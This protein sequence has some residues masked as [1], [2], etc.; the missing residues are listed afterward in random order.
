MKG[1]VVVDLS[2]MEEIGTTWQTSLWVRKGVQQS[3]THTR[4]RTEVPTN[5]FRF[6]VGP[7][8]VHAPKFGGARCVPE[9]HEDQRAVRCRISAGTYR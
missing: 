4:N 8:V 7:A 3:V 6:V 1:G 5:F 2:L 9:V